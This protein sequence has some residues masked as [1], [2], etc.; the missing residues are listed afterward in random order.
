[1]RRPDHG[2]NPHRLDQIRSVA[3]GEEQVLARQVGE[4][5]KGTRREV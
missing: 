4:E 1:M 5:M 3:S 2:A